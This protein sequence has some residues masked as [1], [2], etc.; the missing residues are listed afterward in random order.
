[1]IP[2]RWDRPA[3]FCCIRV[4]RSSVSAPAGVQQH[5]SLLIVILAVLRP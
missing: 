5:Y 3:G 1:M 4:G 2:A